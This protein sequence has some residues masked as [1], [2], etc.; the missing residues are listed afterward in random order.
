MTAKLRISVAL[1]LVAVIAGVLL[2]V[3]LS[4]GDDEP[5]AETA[6]SEPQ[7]GSPKAESAPEP[8]P[9]DAGPAPETTAEE[10]ADSSPATD[11]RAPQEPATADAAPDGPTFD[12][13][14]V[15]PRGDA[16]IAGRAEPGA[17]VTVRDAGEDI[18]TVVADERGEWVLLPDESL[19]A[20][21]RE[22]TI[23]E[24]RANGD[25]VESEQSVV[26]SIPE[27]DGAADETP[28]AVLVEREGDAASRA[29]QLP[30]TTEEMPAEAPEAAE[31]GRK[32]Q[33]PAEAGEPASG[34][35][36]EVIVETGV[37]ID[38]VDYDEAGEMIISGRAEP[39]SALNVYV[40]DVYVGTARTGDDGRWELRPGE[41]LSPGRHTVRVDRVDEEGIVLARIETPLNRARPEE[42]LVG[43][44]RVVVQPGN[45]LWRIARRAYGGGIHFSVIYEANRDTIRD[46]NLIYPGQVFA[47]PDLD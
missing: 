38:S 27:R 30:E 42:L 28:L 37:G 45:S 18:G 43:E 5:P 14:R 41:R 17:E 13:V 2:G 39:G 36:D 6:R 47:I 40:D 19:P 8:K 9:A 15:N 10:E 16:V 34:A 7:S 26:L 29:L 23:V 12:V 21:D 25:V 4:G 35:M 44:A 3:F 33:E 22:L 46:P 24:R 1:A 32:P 11:E 20:G 31:A